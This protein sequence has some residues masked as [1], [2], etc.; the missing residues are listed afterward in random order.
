M[1]RKDRVMRAYRFTEQTIQEIRQI[2]ERLSISDTEAISRAVHFYLISL[3]T[4]EETIR[5]NKLIRFEDYQRIEE[6][7]RKALYRLGEVEGKLEEKDKLLEEKERLITL[8]TENQRKGFWKRI[9][10]SFRG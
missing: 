1:E 3:D 7:L 10:S 2:A 8:L 9:L 6:Q 5:N 4:E